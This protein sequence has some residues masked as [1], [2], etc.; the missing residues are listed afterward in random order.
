LIR[1]D[2]YTLAALQQTQEIA[3]LFTRYTED[4]E[5]LDRDKTY[6]YQV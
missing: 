4:L 3:H 2:T 1:D 5:T 6:K